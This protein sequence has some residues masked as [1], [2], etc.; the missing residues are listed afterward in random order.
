M[1]QH[2]HAVGEVA[3]AIGDEGDVVGFLVVLPGIHDEGVIDGN[4]ENVIH[5]Q[6]LES[7]N[8]V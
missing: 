1:Y 3:V 4:A 6:L 7:Y 8:F 2:A 5:A